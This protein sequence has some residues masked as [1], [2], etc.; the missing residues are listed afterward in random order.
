MFSVTQ[1]QTNWSAGCDCS[2]RV[3]HDHLLVKVGFGGGIETNTA[4]QVAQ[5]RSKSLVLKGLEDQGR[6][7]IVGAHYSFLSGQVS[8]LES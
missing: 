8:L 7:R 2:I 5:V 4:Y 6:I 3:H 1:A